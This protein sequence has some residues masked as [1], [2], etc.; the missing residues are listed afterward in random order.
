MVGIWND[1]YNGEIQSNG[2]M[3]YKIP[4]DRKHF[5]I[6]DLCSLLGQAVVGF[7]TH[8]FCIVFTK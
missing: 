2:S 5:S 1:E 3:L 6:S 8:Q 7:F 4:F